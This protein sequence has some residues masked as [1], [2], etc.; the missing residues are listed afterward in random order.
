MRPRSVW[1]ASTWIALIA[2]AALW[3]V[4]AL[5]DAASVPDPVCAYR[6]LHSFGKPGPGSLPRAT[7]LRGSDGAL[8]GTAQHGGSNDFGTVFRINPDGSGFR[9]LVHFDRATS[10]A[11]PWAGVIQGTDGALYGTTPEGGAHG[12]GT[13]FRVKIDGTALTVLESFSGAETGSHPYGTVLQGADGALYGTTSDGGANGT[14]T[15]YKMNRDGTGFTVLMSFADATTG[16]YSYAELIQGPDGALY[17]TASSGGAAG[18]GT[19]FRLRTDGAGFAVLKHFAGGAGGASPWGAVIRASNGVLYGTTSYGGAFDNGA[20]YR[21]N[22]DGSGFGILNSFQYAATGQFPATALIE[23]AGGF[24]YGTTSYGG[25]L[26][27]YGTAFKIGLDGALF[28]TLT[29]FQYQATSDNLSDRT[30]GVILGGDAMLYG[31]TPGD[32]ETGAGRIYRL[33]VDG[34]GFELIFSNFSLYPDMTEGGGEP[35][36]GVIEGHDGWLYGVAYAGGLFD[37]GTVFKVRTDG[38]GFTVLK[39]LYP[40]TGSHPSGALVQAA[41]GTLFGTTLVGGNPGDGTIFRLETDGSGFS[42]VNTFRRVTTGAYPTG[43]TIASDGRLYGT[44]REGGSSNSGIV[45]RANIDGTGLSVLKQLGGT[46][47]GRPLAPVVQGLDGSLYGTTTNGSNVAGTMF[48]LHTDGSGFATLLDRG[49]DKR[50][51]QAPDGMF[52]ATI[53]AGYQNSGYIYRVRP[54]G[55]GYSV[56]HTFPV[57]GEGINPAGIMLAA[58]GR[59]YGTTMGGGFDDAG[60]LYGLNID[61]SGFS[62]LVEFERVLQGQLPESPLIQGTDGV[63]YGTTARGG[64]AG[65]GTVFRYDPFVNHTPPVARCKNVTV[66]STSACTADVSIDDGSFDPDAGDRITMSQEPAGPYPVGDTLVTL[67]VTDRGCA[68]TTCTATVTVLAGTPCDDGN[69]CTTADHCDETG[70]IGGPPL[71]CDDG[72]C[73]TIDGCDPASGCTHAPYTVPPAIVVQPDLD[74]GGGSCPAL[75]PPNHRYVDFGVADTGIEATS[76]C[77]GV[78]YAFESCDSSQAED[79]PGGADGIT[80]RD[81]VYENEALHLRAERDGT[82]SPKGR[83]YTMTMIATDACGNSVTSSPFTVCVWHDKRN[84]PDGSGGNVYAPTPGTGDT[85]PGT[86]GTYGAACGLGCGLVCGEEGQ[87]HDSSDD[88]RPSLTLT[89]LASGGVRLDWALPAPGDPYPPNASYEIWR[90]V[91]GET[92]FEKLAE[93]PHSVNTYTDLGVIDGIDYEWSVNALY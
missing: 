35:G 22:S 62:S 68:T 79:Q 34:S 23:G 13:V 75:W 85:R 39:D 59:L 24:L 60:T 5:G 10:G 25:G 88:D 72:D 48:T 37:S 73:C 47:G 17:G 31:T 28:T 70:C 80:L 16:S 14:G 53:D 58:D 86:N 19:V 49:S 67:S 38:T 91:R 36:P 71:N 4:P 27:A 2:G 50:L 44:T 45:F 69:A 26:S 1:P 40:T 32:S 21:L 6:V 83:R 54:D 52:Y 46:S 57:A 90:R 81:C 55:S 51:A 93:L 30:G 66:A 76:A 12:L 82:C 43:L 56:L 74:G 61:G 18:W 64:S 42:V 3:A 84:G 63:L 92:R 89:P 15:V 7:L 87:V 77:G 41:D 29:T 33:N 65:G 8:Y 78:T 11:Y 20:I 9:V